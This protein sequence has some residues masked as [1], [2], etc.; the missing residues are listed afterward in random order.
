MI[1]EA[2]GTRMFET[3]KQAALKTISKKDNKV[4]EI[5]KVLR[6]EI[7]PTLENLRKERAIY[8]KW[9]TTQDEVEKLTRFTVA[10][11]YFKAKVCFP[12]ANFSGNFANIW[13]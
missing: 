6:E 4:E 11:D 8:S 12:A 7:T 3:K 1:E 9:T 13:I 5:A 10:Y 2:A